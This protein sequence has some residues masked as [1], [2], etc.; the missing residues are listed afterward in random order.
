[1]GRWGNTVAG[2]V[3]NAVA[4]ETARYLGIPPV[5]ETDENSKKPKASDVPPSVK[6][7]AEVAAREAA[8][9]D[10]NESSS[11]DNTGAQH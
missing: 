10:P 11:K 8:D 5:R 9:R 2:P 4:M 1:D 6:Y 3:F 7:A